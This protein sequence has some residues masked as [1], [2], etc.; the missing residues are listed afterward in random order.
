MDKNAL[1]VL[2]LTIGI[3]LVVNFVMFGIV[4]GLTRGDNRWIRSITDTLTKPME[5]S[6]RHYDELRRRME[7]LSED[8]KKEK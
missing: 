7:E 2:L 1:I 6:T 5:K 4:R 8:E 3:I